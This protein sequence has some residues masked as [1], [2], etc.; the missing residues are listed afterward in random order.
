MLDECKEK[1]ADASALAAQLPQDL[2][3]A[4]AADLADAVVAIILGSQHG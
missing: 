1:T 3:D 2:L 4:V